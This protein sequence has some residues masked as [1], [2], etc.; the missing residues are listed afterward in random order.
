MKIAIV[1]CGYVA[2]FYARTLTNHPNLELSGVFDTAPVS[3]NRFCQHWSAK[4]YPSYSAMLDDPDVDIIVNLTNPESHYAV[5]KAALDAGKHVYSEKPLAMTYE[6][7][8]ELVELAKVNG[9]YLAGAPCSLLG[10]CAQTMWKAIRDGMVGTVR[11]V[12][13]NLDDGMVH[14][15]NPGSSWQGESGVYWPAKDEFEVG[16]TFEHAGYYLTWLSAFIGQATKV[17]AYAAQQLPDKGIPVDVQTPDFSVGLVEYESGVVARITCSIIAPIDRSLTV[18]GDKGIL[19][20]KEAWRYAEPVYFRPWRQPRWKRGLKR[21]AGIQLDSPV[22][23]VRAAKFDPPKNGYTMDFSRGIAELSEAIQQQRPC[24]L[25]AEMALQTTEI[26][27]A[28]Q[29]PERFGGVLELRSRVGA[30]EPMTWAR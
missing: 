23:P 3:L 12:Y 1:G 28:L 5:T 7:A 22:K 15:T 9:L 14:L 17:T 30:V 6:L 29:H 27:E 21:F 13:A 10:E 18:I 4:P 19:Y 2:D 11:L 20:V 8:N 24:R 25:S 16:C 26:T